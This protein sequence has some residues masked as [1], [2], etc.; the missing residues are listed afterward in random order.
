VPTAKK[1][2]QFAPQRQH[3]QLKNEQVSGAA[4]GLYEQ[5]LSPFPMTDQP[6]SPKNDIIPVQQRTGAL[7]AQ[8]W[9][10]EIGPSTARRI[11]IPEHFNRLS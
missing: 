1:A 7:C 6:E 8:D 5:A 9:S 2:F 10:T 11:R 3:L 4:F